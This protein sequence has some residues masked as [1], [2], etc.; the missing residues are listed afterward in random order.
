MGVLILH[1]SGASA[2]GLTCRV[3]G[4]F[5]PTS[6]HIL[7]KQHTRGLCLQPAISSDIGGEDDLNDPEYAPCPFCEGGPL[8]GKYGQYR[9]Q[10]ALSRALELLEAGLR[11]DEDNMRETL[12]DDIS[13]T[14][15]TDGDAYRDNRNAERAVNAAIEEAKQTAMLDGELEEHPWF[16][17]ML[18]VIRPAAIEQV[19]GYWNQDNER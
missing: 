16:P 17:D 3:G 11:L 15:I 10:K 13:A 1:E 7:C 4:F 18:E 5:S 19:R 9:S 8:H 6:R 12:T 14:A 2:G